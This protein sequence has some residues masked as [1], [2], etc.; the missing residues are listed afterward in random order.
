M[1][2][3]ST[4][5]RNFCPWS[6]RLPLGSIQAGLP[7]REI[8]CPQTPR[9]VVYPICFCYI[10]DIWTIQSMRVALIAMFSALLCLP[11]LAA[12][13]DHVQEILVQTDDGTFAMRDIQFIGRGAPEL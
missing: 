8:P 12:A 10:A 9:E 4:T 7:E 6:V 5:L 13:D 11:I 3:K 1:P 2:R